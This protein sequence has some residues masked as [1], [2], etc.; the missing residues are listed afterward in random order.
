MQRNEK[1]E[2]EKL[3]KTYLQHSRT[4]KN[5]RTKLILTFPQSKKVISIQVHGIKILALKG[6]RRR[7]VKT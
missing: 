1:R 4:G 2:R 6:I 3:K 5:T 7:K